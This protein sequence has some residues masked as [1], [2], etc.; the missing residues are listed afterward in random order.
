MSNNASITSAFIDAWKRLDVEAILD[1]FTDDAVYINIP[2][3]PENH[4]KAQIRAFIEGFIGSCSEIEFIVHKQIEGPDGTVMN[5][6]TDRLKMNGSWVE[7]PVMG[8]YEF[9]DG[10]ISAWRDYFDM[11]PFQQA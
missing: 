4:G 3:Q 8:V 1:F 9:R 6:R 7:L 5:E 11:G 2:M 10:K